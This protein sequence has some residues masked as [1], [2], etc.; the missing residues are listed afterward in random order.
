MNTEGSCFGL[1]LIVDEIKVSS[2][3]VVLSVGVVGA[4]SGRA[5]PFGSRD[6]VWLLTAW[7]PPYPYLLPSVLAD[8]FRIDSRY[9]ASY[10]SACD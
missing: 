6:I 4:L 2:I 9:V 5:C 3:M 7:A 8:H 10:A 1:E